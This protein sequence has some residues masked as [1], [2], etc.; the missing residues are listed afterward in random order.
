MKKCMQIHSSDNVATMLSVGCAGDTVQIIDYS[1]RVVGEVELKSDIPYAHKVV[2]KA[3]DAGGTVIKYGE[4]MG[5]SIEK[6]SRGAYAHIHNVLSTEAGKHR[7]D[8]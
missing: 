8:T 4:P 1:Q 3:L 2:I 7:I 5:I 6:L